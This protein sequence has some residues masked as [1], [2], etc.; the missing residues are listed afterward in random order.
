[1]WNAVTIISEK[2]AG[3]IDIQPAPCFTPL[4]Q[5]DL[6]IKNGKVIDPGTNTNDKCDVAIKRNRI[7]AVGRGIPVESAARVIDASGQIVTPGLVDLQSEV[8]T[9]KPGAYADVAL[10]KVCDGDF[11]FYDVFMNA[12]NGK[13]LLQN[14]PSVYHRH[15]LTTCSSHLP[16][17]ASTSSYP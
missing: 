6:L 11:T 7:A 15:R 9:L 10:F 3:A 14:T 12:R 2:H 17:S 16:S 8:G 1:M 13:Q 4:M 5:F